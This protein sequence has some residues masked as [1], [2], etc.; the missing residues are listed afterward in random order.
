MV[1]NCTAV[2]SCT[3][4]HLVILSSLKNQRTSSIHLHIRDRI[5]KITREWGTLPVIFMIICP[6]TTA[7][8]TIV[9]VKTGK[10]H[11]VIVFTTWMIIWNWRYVCI[12]I[13]NL[14]IFH[15]FL[16]VSNVSRINTIILTPIIPSP[17]IS[18]E[19]WSSMCGNN[20]ADKSVEKNTSQ[21][22]WFFGSCC[23]LQKYVFTFANSL[24]ILN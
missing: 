17:N 18:I 11:D 6:I 23:K 4:N 24:H 22:R 1:C 7:S 13:T 8:I 14:Q 15:R 3:W 10:K 5:S 21:T 16:R 9:K 12:P 2:F 19:A 20:S